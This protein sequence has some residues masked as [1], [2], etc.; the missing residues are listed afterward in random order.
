MS[1]WDISN[2]SFRSYAEFYDVWNFYHESP[3]SSLTLYSFYFMKTNL[4][5]VT[6]LII[7]TNSLNLQNIRYHFEY[8]YYTSSSII[9][10]F[11][12]LISFHHILPQLDTLIP[13]SYWDHIIRGI[14]YFLSCI[15]FHLP[16]CLSN[17]HVN[18]LTLITSSWCLI[19][20]ASLRYNWSRN[21][22][23]ITDMIRP[24]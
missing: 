10:F 12:L 18:S 21:S 22:F 2:S 8:S 23:Y 14:K 3:F 20:N 9:I 15:S 17:F 13:Y 24:Q 1:R 16:L 19:H 7:F 5:I 4:F 11:F 6:S